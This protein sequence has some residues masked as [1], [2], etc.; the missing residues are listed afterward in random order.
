MKPMRIIHRLPFPGRTWALSRELDG[1]DVPIDDEV[2][3]LLAATLDALWPLLRPRSADLDAVCL[4]PATRLPIDAPAQPPGPHH[5]ALRAGAPALCLQALLAWVDATTA[6]GICP[7]P[8]CSTWSSLRFDATLAWVDHGEDAELEL[9]DLETLAAPRRLLLSRFDAGWW[10]AGPIDD[11]TVEPPLALALDQDGAVLH[12]TL[13]AC[14]D[15]WVDPGQPGAARLQAALV[16]LRSLGWTDD[17][18]SG[19]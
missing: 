10:V 1:L 11:E 2:R 16:R 8:S 12:L 17:E 14:W 7:A 18:L 9:H 13:A 3:A 15:C 4:D 19:A 6:A 5:L